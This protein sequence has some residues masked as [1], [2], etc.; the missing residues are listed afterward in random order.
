VL[1]H[2]PPHSS[3]TPLVV[4]GSMLSMF[5]HLQERMFPFKLRPEMF[6]VKQKKDG[7]EHWTVHIRLNQAIE[8]VTKGSS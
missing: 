5:K 6:H 4:F 7:H 1:V 2:P 8:P 3:N